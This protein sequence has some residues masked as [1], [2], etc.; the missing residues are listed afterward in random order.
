[1]T[2]NELIEA[3]ES[4]RAVLPSGGDAPVKMPDDLLVRRA[5]PDEGRDSVYVTDVDEN[6]LTSADR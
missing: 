2:I 4:A 6:G 3:L 1:M 5:I